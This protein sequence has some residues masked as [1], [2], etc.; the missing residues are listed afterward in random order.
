M[1]LESLSRGASRGYFFEQDRSALGLLRK[2]IQSL[3]VDN[4][5][6]IVAGDVFK[7]FDKAQRAATANRPCVAPVA[8]IIFLD[9]PYRFLREQPENLRSLIL[10]WVGGFLTVNGIIVF[11]HDA[12][13]VLEFPELIR[14]DQRNYGS[15]AVEFLRASASK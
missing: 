6:E 9:P 1:G 13:D 3:G 15:M 5:C 14:F 11:R 8:D 10:H 7:Y 12:D 4:R 2:N